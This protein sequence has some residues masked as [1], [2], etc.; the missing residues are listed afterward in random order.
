MP[1]SITALAEHLL[2]LLD[3][4]GA[5]LVDFDF[6]PAQQVLRVRWH[7]HLTPT[8][9]VQGT[10]AGASLRQ[11]GQ[12]PRRLLIDA[13]LASG[14]WREARPWLQ[15]EWL[16]QVVARGLRAIAYV[17]SPDPT[18]MFS[19][20]EFVAGM[21]RLVPLGVFRNPLAAWQWLVRCG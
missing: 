2:D 15:Y 21:R 19:S 8:G 16:P 10:Q 4:H 5:L 20:H 17:H 11:D 1:T 18:S 12:A 3:A 9:V 13:S 6:F 14:D 7:G